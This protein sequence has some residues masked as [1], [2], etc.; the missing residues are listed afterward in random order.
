MQSVLNFSSS[1]RHTLIVGAPCSGKDIFASHSIKNI[2]QQQ[3]SLTV[4]FM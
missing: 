4:L 1:L 3:P 2:K